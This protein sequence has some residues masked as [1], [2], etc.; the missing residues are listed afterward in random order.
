M[1]DNMKRPWALLIL[2][3]CLLPQVQGQKFEV[4][5]EVVARNLDVPWSLAFAPDGRI[6]FTERPGR[7]R[8]IENNVVRTILSIDVAA[9]GEGGLLGLS[10]DPS[11]D[12]N[13]FLYAYYTYRDA[14]GALLNRIVRFTESS[15]I[16]VDQRIILDRIPG[17]AIHDGGRVKF[18]PDGKLYVTTGD[19]AQGA[20]AQDLTSLAG[21][22][23]RINPDGSVPSDNPFPG[24]LVYTYGHRNP[25]GLD[26]HPVTGKIYE[27]EHGPTGHD[28]V[29][30][31]EAGRNYGWPIVT[32]AA[33]DPRFVDPLI[34]T[35]A[36]TWA[37][38]GATFYRRDRFPDL[39]GAFLIATLRGQH[40]RVL[41]LSSSFNS[42]TFSD[43]ALQGTHGRLRD[44]VEGPDGFL[45]VFTNN[46]DGRGN[47]TPDDDRLLKIV[48]A[49][50]PE[51]R[52]EQ[53]LLP[54]VL[55][56][57]LIGVR[58]LSRRLR[59]QA[60]VQKIVRFVQLC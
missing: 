6:F 32:A 60:S 48:S 49:Q 28:E 27:T 58:A 24:S 45:Y 55:A 9:V 42:V 57:A 38:S 29:N 18:G 21:K 25:Q 2:V 23:L 26:W 46:R 54:V 22:V 12:K 53:F 37:P 16:L 15:G 33:G 35:G 7:I 44:V 3:L 10:L 47:P 59:A 20:L 14:Q 17:S 39:R 4:Q 34:E 5:V 56:V 1:M 13:R 41:T 52:F 19:A 36:D 30:I 43:A 40:L 51:F 31:L 50:I 8:V 11:F